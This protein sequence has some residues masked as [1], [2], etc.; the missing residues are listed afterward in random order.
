MAGLTTTP[1]DSALGPCGPMGARTTS[2][3]AFL[4]AAT[5][6][7]LA[8]V[9][10]T[11][12]W[13][14]PMSAMAGIPM[15]G[16]W[17]MSMAWMPMCGQTWL[18]AAASFLVMWI[19]MMMAMMLP[20]LVPTLRHYRQA[21]GIAGEI[22]SDLWTV[23]VG[24]GYFAVWTVIGM[25]VFAMGAGLAAAATQ[26]PPLARIGPLAA[27][28]VVLFAGV[29]QL[30]SWKTQQLASCHDRATRCHVLP[31]NTIAALR[32]GLQ[33]GV[34]CGACCG[35]LMVVLLVLGVMDLSVMALVTVA[36]TAERLLPYQAVIRSIGAAVVAA[37]FF[38]VAR[39]VG[40]G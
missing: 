31:A 22:R 8:S 12:L 2:E 28:I 27:G 5:L 36:I 24:A 40:L 6:V 4:I 17:I 37:G 33:L 32:H 11:V 14:G 13:C 15:P 10:A 7:F 21:I 16:G 39:E 20:S 18:G 3:R 35:N 25:F 38:L 19:V 34:H 30:T 9:A 29:I 23:H 1:A 26:V